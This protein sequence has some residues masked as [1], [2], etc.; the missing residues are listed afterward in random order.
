[1]PF[2]AEKARC[3]SQGIANKKKKTN[4][5]ITPINNGVS[6]YSVL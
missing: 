4:P 3:V 2:F 6:L 1:M 5:G